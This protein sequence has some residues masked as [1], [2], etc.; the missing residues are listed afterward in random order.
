VAFDRHRCVV[1]P[2]M[3]TVSVAVLLAGHPV[4]PW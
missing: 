4:A 3:V 1:V 2:V